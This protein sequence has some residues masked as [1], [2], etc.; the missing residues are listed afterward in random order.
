VVACV[1]VS[2]K[3]LDVNGKL[4]HNVYIRTPTSRACHLITEKMI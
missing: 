1:I 2:Y 3:C 4:N